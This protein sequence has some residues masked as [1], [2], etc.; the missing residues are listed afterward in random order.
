MNTTVKCIY[1]KALWDYEIKAHNYSCGDV[2][3]TALHRSGEYPP[4][5]Y[6]LIA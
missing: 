6:R 4:W 1:R 3:I 5:D 2:A